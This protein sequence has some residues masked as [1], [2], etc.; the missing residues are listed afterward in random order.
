MDCEFS[1]TSESSTQGQGNNRNFCTICG[2]KVENNLSIILIRLFK[3]QEQN[4]IIAATHPRDNLEFRVTGKV[5]QLKGESIKKDFLYATLVG[6]PLMRVS[7][8]YTH[9]YNKYII[10]HNMLA[11]QNIIYLI[12]NVHDIFNIPKF[13]KQYTMQQKF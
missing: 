6:L 10:R 8:N 1:I 5:A 4:C 12:I 2:C 9:R 13:C 11:K 3:S 7:P